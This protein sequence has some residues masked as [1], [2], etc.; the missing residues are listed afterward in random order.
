MDFAEYL[1]NKRIEKGM[2]IRGLSKE[3]GVDVHHLISGEKTP[4]PESVLPIL[5]ALSLKDD[6]KFHAIDIYLHE[7]KGLDELI[8]FYA[9]KNL[10]QILRAKNILEEV[11]TSDLIT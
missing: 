8:Q 2:S 7:K 10:S 1:N 3:A 4:S 5:K 6:E 11:L 9:K